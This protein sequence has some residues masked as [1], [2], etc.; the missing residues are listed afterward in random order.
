MSSVGTACTKSNFFYLKQLDLRQ[1]S[2]FLREKNVFSRTVHLYV[3]CIYIYIH[4]TL[5]YI[6]VHYI[7]HAY[8]YK[9]LGGYTQYNI[10]YTIQYTRIQFISNNAVVEK[11]KTCQRHITSRQFKFIVNFQK[12]QY[13]GCC[14]A[15]ARVRSKNNLCISLNS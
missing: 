1:C 11:M 6:L 4:N 10:Q 3:Q 13:S 15:T 12:L 9:S 5:M 7:V 14:C 2:T 8:N